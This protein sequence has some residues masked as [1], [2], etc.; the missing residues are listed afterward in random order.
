MHGPEENNWNNF[1][2]LFI[3]NDRPHMFSKIRAF[4]NEPASI[5]TKKENVTYCVLCISHDSYLYDAFHCY[6]NKIFYNYEKFS[7]AEQVTCESW[8]IG[9]CYDTTIKHFS[10][11]RLVYFKFQSWQCASRPRP[12][13]VTLVTRAQ[14]LSSSFSSTSRLSKSFLFLGAYRTGG[15]LWLVFTTIGAVYK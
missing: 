4:I 12:T 3:W 13:I 2:V 11:T 9:V 5:K 15:R 10:L 6:L 14:I 8:C 7:T 1:I